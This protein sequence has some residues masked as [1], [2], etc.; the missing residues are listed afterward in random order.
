MIRTF[1]QPAM[2]VHPDS[3][4]PSAGKPA[5]VVAHLAAAGIPLD[6]R[7]FP[8]VTRADLERAHDRAYVDGIL[9]LR[10]PNGFGDRSRAVASSLLHTTGSLLAAARDALARRGVAFSPT[11][12]FHHASPGAAAGYC[13][14]NGLV[15]T[16]ATLR[17][18]GLVRRVGIVDCDYHYGDGTDACIAAISA[19]GWLRHYTAGRRC[20]E[21]AHAQGFLA[22]LPAVMAEMRDCDLLLYQAGAD[23]HVDDPLGGFLTSEEMAMRDAIVFREARRLG[24]PIAWNLAGGYQRGPDGGLGPVLAI[25]EATARA[26]LAAWPGGEGRG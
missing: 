2:V 3:F 13:T 6:V 19:G 11:S 18:E 26:C 23:P 15:V 20:S 8:P 17:A 22:G 4:S 9:D 16:A 24:L 14:F 10:L 25:H 12:G 1:Y 21:R 5:A 7:A